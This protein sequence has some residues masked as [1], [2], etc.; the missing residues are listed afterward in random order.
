MKEQKRFCL[1]IVCIVAL[2]ACAD[3]SAKITGI[4]SNGDL[5]Y[6]FMGTLRPE[7]FF[8]KNITFLNNNETDDKVWYARHTIDAKLNILYGAKLQQK[9]C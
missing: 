1:F 3:V 7:M 5:E 6:S 2:S 8:G 9:R 4:S